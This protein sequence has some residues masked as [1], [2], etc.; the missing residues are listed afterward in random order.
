MVRYIGRGPIVGL[1]IGNEPELYDSFPWYKSAA[2][3]HLTG[4][5]KLPAAIRV[6][7]SAPTPVM[8]PKKVGCSAEP[9]SVG[10]CAAASAE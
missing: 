8:L 5:F 2:G 10:I 7:A 9:T 4:L 1:E 3:V 6:P